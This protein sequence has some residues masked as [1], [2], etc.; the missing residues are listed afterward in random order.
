MLWL[1]VVVLAVICGRLWLRLDAAEHRLIELED[2]RLSMRRYL[3][4]RERMAEGDAVEENPVAEPEADSEAEPG[5]EEAPARGS[6]QLIRGGGSVATREPIHEASLEAPAEDAEPDGEW[7]ETRRRFSFDFEDIFGRK[8]AIWAGGV[9][10]AVAGV[11]LV[12]YSIEQGLVTPGLRVAMAFL[13]G[14]GLIAAAEAAYR[15]RERVADPRVAQALAGA[16]LATLYAGFY[17]AGTQYGLIGQTVAFLGLAAVTA[18]AIGLSFRFG[19]PSAVLGLVGGFAAP[20]LVGGESANLPLLVL[21]LALVTAGLTV[22]GRRQRRPWMGLAALVGGLG[23]GALL[24]LSGDLG[25]GDI[26]ALGLYLVLLGAVIPAI[27]ASTAFE[28]YLRLGSAAV[29]SLQLALL[30]EQGGYAPLTWALYL[31]LGAVLAGYGWCKPELREGSAL[32]AAIALLLALRWDAPDPQLFVSVGAGILLVFAA[33][34]LALQWRGAARRI[35][36][37][38]LALVPLA[39]ALVA[40]I[41]FG[42]FDSDPLE[43]WLALAALVCALFP[44]AGAWAAREIDRSGEFAALVASASLLVFL[45]GLLLTPGWAAPL[46]AL[47]A[48]AAPFALARKN[49]SRPLAIV[50]FAGAAIALFVLA[51]TPHFI[52]E[53]GRAF[54]NDG[55]ANMLHACLRWIA[56]ALPWAAIGWQ[57][58]SGPIRWPA[59]ALA[60]ALVYGM[61]AQIVPP[62]ALTLTAAAGA[63]ALNWTVKRTDGAVIAWL[64]IALAWALAPLGEW[65]MACISSLAADPVFVTDLPSPRE[66]ALYLAPLAIAL[67]A[68][69]LP[70]VRAELPR[71]DTRWLAVPLVLIAAHV[72]F[73]QIFAIETVTTFIAQGL[74][75]RTLW[76]AALLGFGWIA[77]SQSG[78]RTWLAP[79]GQAL[80]GA[81]LAHFI[82]FTAILHNPLFVPQALGPTPIANLAG[83]A[84]GVAIA[85]ALLLRPAEHRW[86]RAA[87]DVLV[88]ALSALAALT[89]LRQGFAG[90]IPAGIEMTQTEDLLR[91]LLGIVLALFFLFVG[92]RRNERSWRI[93]SLVLMLIA[94][95]K[96]FIFDAAGLEGLLRIASFTALGASLIGIGWLYSRLLGTGKTAGDTSPG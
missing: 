54:G 71:L 85:T 80:A 26:L 52:G 87:A 79:V 44:S 92:S 66:I 81:A 64:V 77:L 22:S 20:A 4:T 35:D 37:L 65:A 40:Y 51:I 42:D 39:L 53:V 75:E 88:M 17:L 11:F 23:W 18:G 31:L 9:T 57:A 3:Y 48:L 25:G 5:I 36:R 41:Q 32:A 30:V 73:K 14:F 1:I 72:A 61:A 6:V 13:F 58:R 60:A 56:A 91:S 10:L 46:M 2:F 45:T 27:A 21:Y 49:D 59:Q 28:R 8:L 33:V 86:W 78:S 63:I 95:I 70:I 69:R 29:A 7:S 55:D 12:L 68:V 74:A 89:L 38:Q 76:E 94:L 82:L 96:V 24:L 43:P 34:P 62:M 93:G 90:S 83:A 84:Y 47:P 16:G 50:C 67:I 15:F 19:L